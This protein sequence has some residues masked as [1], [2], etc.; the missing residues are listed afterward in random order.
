VI[1]M[2]HA[3]PFIMIA[4][5]L[6]VAGAYA[7]PST[8]SITLVGY[9]NATYNSGGVTGTVGWFDFGF[10]AGSAWNQLGNL[11]PNGGTITMTQNGEPLG[12]Y[13]DTYYITA[14]DVTGCSAAASFS[15][16]AATPL[17]TITIA[18]YAATGQSY[19]QNITQN[20]FAPIN[21]VWNAVQPYIQ[22]EG[23]TV[24]YGFILMS[25]FLVVW[26][27]TRGTF[28]ATMIGIVTAG[29]F[30]SMAVGLQ[31]GIP[32]E[33]TALAQAIMYT[34]LAATITMFTFK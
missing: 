30:C 32:P 2:K 27:R 24:F 11:T 23:A 4:L 26:L 5:V 34:S 29:L 7:V 10:S 12:I 3:I 21:L 31:L 19:A 1:E 14:C 22:I 6:L 16:T 33:F 8:P 9:D 20:G 18:N 13:G 15:T 28:I 17:P 25:V